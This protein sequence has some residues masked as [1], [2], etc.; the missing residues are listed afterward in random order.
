MLVPSKKQRGA[1]AHD[2][3]PCVVCPPGLP[4]K[5]APTIPEAKSNKKNQEATRSNKKQKEATKATKSNAKHADV[6]LARSS[7]TPQH[8]SHVPPACPREKC[9]LFQRQ[10][11]AT[12][13]NKKQQEATRSNTKQQE[14]TRNNEKQQEASRSNK[15]QQ[16]ATR[17]SKKQQ[18]ATRS[19]TKQ[20]EATRSMLMLGKLG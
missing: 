2:P 9:Q 15:K 10:Q 8:V 17:S 12:K 19:N 5:E 3:A 4:Q 6:P 13:S 20:Q 11:E 16:E 14:A 7:M 18:E 1:L